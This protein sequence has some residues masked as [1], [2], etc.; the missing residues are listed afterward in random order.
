MAGIRDPHQTADGRT[1]VRFNVRSSSARSR[2]SAV[3]TWSILIVVLAVCLGYFLVPNPR[4]DFST[5]DTRDAD[6]YLALSRSLV[7][8]R[9][10]TRSLDPHAY[11]PHLT[12]PPGL[13]VLLMPV[14]ALAGMPVDLLVVKV[15]MI[16]YGAIGI[17]LAYFYARRLSGSPLT[18]LCVP[19]LL[20]LNPHYWQ[21]SRM[22]DSEVPTVV[23]ALLALILADFGWARGMIRYR[24]AFA[25]GLIAG[26]GMLIRGSF[27][28]ALLLPLACLV[29][30]RR[31]PVDRN[32]MLRR[33]LVYAAG[34]LLPFAVWVG[35]N[36]TIDGRLLGLDGIN[37]LAMIFRSAPVDP[38][39]PLRTLSQIVHD[40]RANLEGSIIY[41]I[42]RSLIPGLWAP[43]AWERM[44]W[45]GPPVAAAVSLAAIV[46]SCRSIRNL[47][48][49][50]MYGSMAALNVF[51]A[52]GGLARL[53]VPVTCLVAISLPVGAETL[54]VFRRRGA[55]WLAAGV[56]GAA[57][58]ASL[59]FYIAR[60]EQHPYADA[61]YAALADMFETARG[62]DN[63]RGNVLT[64]NPQAFTL[65]TGLPAPMTVPK[66]GI[67]PD[68]AYVILPSAE[69]RPDRLSGTLIARNGVWSLIALT[70]PLNLAA[71]RERVDCTRSTISSF[72]VLSNC[73][74]W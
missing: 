50:L 34:F 41:Q 28:G 49:I 38:L 20:A 37:Q 70:A 26:F 53:W 5:F 1:A 7:D 8:G 42:P 47:P 51:Y 14:V 3:A 19:L 57:M 62:A 9:G 66:L 63:L 48:V 69:W 56:T 58:A 4:L 61:N 40:M 29:A 65:Y 46:V 31:E 25:F 13:P 60:H 12:W 67:D 11:V 68:Y 64:P 22:T 16:V 23:W 73:L 2:G 36:S 52:A 59:G 18:H 17:L 55:A 30:R 44:G 39:S 71:I 32:Q 15:G 74:I 72:A 33:Y 45:L 27:F 6:S 21:F 43:A 24:T 10:Y 35:R 54:A